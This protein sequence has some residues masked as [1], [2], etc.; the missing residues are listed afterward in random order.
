VICFVRGSDLKEFLS[1]ILQDNI[2]TVVDCFLISGYILS[3]TV[4]YASSPAAVLLVLLR[5]EVSHPTDMSSRISC[6]FPPVTFYLHFHDVVFHI[7]PFLSSVMFQKRSRNPLLLSL[8]TRFFSFLLVNDCITITFF[9]L[10]V[11]CTHNL[12]LYTD[13]SGTQMVVKAAAGRFKVTMQL[14]AF[15]QALFKSRRYYIFAT[16]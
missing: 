6:L 16:W 14:D 15:S 2:Q 9:P 11:Y 1:T 13:V 5:K 3:S 7:L 10:Y 12:H 8:C 4:S